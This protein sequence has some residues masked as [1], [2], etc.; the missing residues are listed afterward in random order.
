QKIM[1]HGAGPLRTEAGLQQAADERRALVNQLEEIAL[2]RQTHFALSLVE[3]LEAANML[4]LSEAILIGA[5][6][7]RESRGAH[8]RLDYDDQSGTPYS[9]KFVLNDRRQWSMEEIPLHIASHEGG[10]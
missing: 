9:S 10:K 7:R 2:A 5:L 3:K 6:H 4:K 1:W 8:V